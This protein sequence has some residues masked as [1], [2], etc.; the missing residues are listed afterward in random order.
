VLIAFA[1]LW[2]TGRLKRVALLRKLRTCAFDIVFRL[3][4][5]TWRVPYE[6]GI[7]TETIWG[8]WETRGVSVSP[9][10]GEIRAN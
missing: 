2:E 8:S 3:C 5:C 9:N 1:W 7:C 4:N 6:D 10:C